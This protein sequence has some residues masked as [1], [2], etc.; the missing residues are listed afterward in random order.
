MNT[1]STQRAAL[2]AFTAAIFGSLATQSVHA[3]T[4]NV[5]SCSQSA[6]QNAISAA[7]EGDVVAVPAGSCTWGGFSV[8]KGVHIK[9]AGIG[10]TNISLTGTLSL[11][12]SSTRSVQISG[13]SF[14]SGGASPLLRVGGA[15]N[16]VPPLIHNN[17][18]TVN[19]ADVMRY[20]TNGGVIYKNTFTG[21]ANDNGIQHKIPSDTQS[22]STADTMGMRDTNGRSNLY[23][24]DN[25]FTGFLNVA[26]DFDDAARVVFRHN[27]LTNSGVNSHGLATSPVGVRHYE[28]YNNVFRY[29]SSS[30]NQNWWVWLRGGTGVIFGNTFENIVGQMWGDKTEIHFSVRAADD[31]AGAGCCRTYPCKHQIGQNYDGSRYFTDPVIM[32]GNTGNFR[33]GLNPWPSACGNDYN[34]FLKEGRDIV[35]SSVPKGNY[36]PYTYPHP[37]ASGASSTEP[38]PLA[39][40]SNLRVQ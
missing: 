32:W 20:E 22:W 19:G 28:I 9:G 12:K 31:G 30:V 10:Q 6:V 15:W 40:P 36:T 7:A 21:G 5:A 38:S 34:N 11:N 13:F 16:A 35:V 18:F 8:S 25:T 4:I 26:T 14:T 1:Q 17:A 29:P 37:L 23:V 27:S 3:A 24:E 2:V 39:P 33:W